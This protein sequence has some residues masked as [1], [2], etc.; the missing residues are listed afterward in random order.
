MIQFMKKNK[1]VIDTKE[2]QKIINKELKTSLRLQLQQE[3]LLFIYMICDLELDV[4]ACNI[5]SIIQSE[6]DL[7]IIIAL[8]IWAHHNKKV[9]R[10]KTEAHE[11]NL[12]V[13]ELAKSL[14]LEK[15]DG[16]RWLLLYEAEAHSLF[17]NGVYTPIEK[18]SFFTL[19]RQKGIDF[20]K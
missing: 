17:P 13:T 8:D 1:S 12:A 19:L 18:P 5:L 15:Y 2:L 3:T 11:I 10:T 7:A 14:S 20:Y 16:N 9:L 6:N 4:E